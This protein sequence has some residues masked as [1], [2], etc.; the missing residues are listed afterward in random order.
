MPRRGRP[1]VRL[2]GHDYLFERRLT[3]QSLPIIRL[4][5]YDGVPQASS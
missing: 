5:R 2:E 1:K 4:S 3:G